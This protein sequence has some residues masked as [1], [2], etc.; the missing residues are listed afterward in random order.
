MHLRSVFLIFIIS[1]CQFGC[2]AA[3]KNRCSNIKLQIL[4]S[5]G[6]EIN[7]GLASSSY[8]VW[9]D[10]KAK[11]MVDAGGGSSL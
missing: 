4:G 3:D 7:D 10:D 8:L 6:P 5:G 11:I 2:V 9:I 1:C